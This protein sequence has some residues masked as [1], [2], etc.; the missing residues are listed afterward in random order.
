MLR[1]DVRQLSNDG[2]VVVGFSGDFMDEH[3]MIW[4]KA[5]GMVDLTTYLT[6][7]GLT[8]PTDGTLKFANAVSD[9]GCIDWRIVSL[10]YI[11]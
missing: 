3:A 2:R 6:D 9:A 10:T 4:T 8:V 11:L 5:I 7:L 1:R